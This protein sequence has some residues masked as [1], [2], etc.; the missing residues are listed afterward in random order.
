MLEYFSLLQN[1][2]QKAFIDIK[3]AHVLN[4][5]ECEI[6]AEIVAALQPIDL[7]GNAFFIVT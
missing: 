6:V 7:A 1:A 4:E 2:L 3:Q 5:A